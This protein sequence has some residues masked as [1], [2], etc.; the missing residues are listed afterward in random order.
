MKPDGARDQDH[1]L[2]D[3]CGDHRPS[4]SPLPPLPAFLSFDRARIGT[5]SI[6]QRAFI[7]GNGTA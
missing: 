1:G 4:L 3:P 6:A 7:C 5:L 2:R